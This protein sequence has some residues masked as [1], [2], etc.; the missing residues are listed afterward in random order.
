MK[1]Y[2]NKTDRTNSQKCTY[3]KMQGKARK[4]AARFHGKNEALKQLAEK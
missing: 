1:P 2:T 4:K 3:A